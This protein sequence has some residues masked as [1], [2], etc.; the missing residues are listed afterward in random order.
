MGSSIHGSEDGVLSL[1]LVAPL[2]FGRLLGSNVTE[3]RPTS[4]GQ[5]LYTL[6]RHSFWIE[7]CPYR[8]I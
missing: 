8:S 7:V 3:A 2:M 1:L 4:S 5:G 6:S